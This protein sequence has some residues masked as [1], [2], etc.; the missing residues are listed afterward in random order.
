MVDESIILKLQIDDSAS[1]QIE[2]INGHFDKL[3]DRIKSIDNNVKALGIVTVFKNAT[4][5]LEKGNNA[6]L[7]YEKG[8][9]EIRKKEEELANQKGELQKLQVKLNEAHDPAVL[10][11]YRELQNKIK[12]TEEELAIKKKELNSDLINLIQTYMQLG[13]STIPLLIANLSRLSGILS[14]VRGALISTF[15]TNPVG[16]A[17]MGITGA[18]LA[19][20]E[21]FG[22]LPFKISDA[23]NPMKSL[24]DVRMDA[25]ATEV[26]RVS[27]ELEDIGKKADE[28]SKKF[29]ELSKN[30]MNTTGLGD[31][32]KE[33]ERMVGKDITKR[34]V[35]SKPEVLIE[36]ILDSPEFIR[37]LTMHKAGIIPERTITSNILELLK[38]H[39]LPTG[40]VDEAKL[41]IEIMLRERLN[42]LSEEHNKDITDQVNIYSKLKTEVIDTNTALSKFMNQIIMLRRQLETEIER[43][44]SMPLSI[45]ISSAS[46][47]LSN[48]IQSNPSNP[49]SP[50][51]INNIGSRQ[52]IGQFTSGM[53]T[54]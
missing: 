15:I 20:N 39:G 25:L 4:D 53:Y 40:F 54:Y 6:M 33:F 42:S 11:R 41:K 10:E 23:L 16:L 49:K 3:N 1:T 50:A 8:L 9:L 32:G 17:I 14:V 27:T 37:V 29:E 38:R 35:I 18:V 46:S 45:P 7:K 21:A 31:L 28:A 12:I 51:T 30:F 52:I 43:M 22:F 26:R 44:R 36:Q 34:L 47:S 24:N 13:G 5:I 2:K 48:K 19:L